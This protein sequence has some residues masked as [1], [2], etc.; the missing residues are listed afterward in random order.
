MAEI[1]RIQ[2]SRGGCRVKLRAS[3]LAAVFLFLAPGHYTHSGSTY[4]RSGP[5]VVRG[6]F[7]LAAHEGLFRELTS[8]Q[9]APATRLAHRGCSGADS[10]LLVSR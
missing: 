4:E 6:D 9:T 10:N 3:L 8:L 2:A 1:F 5:F 7:P